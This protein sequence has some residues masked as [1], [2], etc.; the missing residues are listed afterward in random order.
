ML[1]PNK[2][3][4]IYKECAAHYVHNKIHKNMISSDIHEL[5]NIQYV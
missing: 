3:I 1:S 5:K 4:F 2:H